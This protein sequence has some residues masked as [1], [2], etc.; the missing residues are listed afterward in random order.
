VTIAA[1]QSSAVIDVSVINDALTEGD[2]TVIVTLASGAYG[3]GVDDSD[4][5]TIADNEPEVSIVANDGSAAETVSPAAPNPGQ[6]TV[7]RTGDTSTAL[8]VFYTVVGSATP[9]FDYTA[10]SGSVVIAAGQSSATID[11]N[12]I[13]DAITEL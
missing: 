9:G 5:V 1:G 7:T 4:T 8:T 3:I 10:L 11:V 2:E 12:V 6:F 13:N